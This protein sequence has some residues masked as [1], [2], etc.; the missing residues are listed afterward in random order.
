V[1]FVGL[2]RSLGAEAE[3]VEKAAEIGPALG[4]AL[5]RSGPTLI[6]VRLDRGFKPS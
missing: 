1:D 6:D 2:A 4:R 5:S 3:R